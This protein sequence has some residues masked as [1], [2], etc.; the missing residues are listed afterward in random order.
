MYDST[1][2][3]DCPSDGDLYLGYVNGRWATYGRLVTLYGRM[4]VVPCSVNA[5]QAAAVCDTEPGDATPDQAPHF[6]SISRQ[7][8][9][10]KPC[11]YCDRSEE[12]AV[13]QALFAAGIPVDQACLGIATLD[14]SIVSGKTAHGYDIVFCQNRGSAQTGGHYDSS[15]V[16]DN[17]WPWYN[18]V[19]TDPPS[20]PLGANITVKRI[21]ISI[22]TDGNGNGWDNAFEQ[23]GIPWASCVG[24]PFL[25]G[26]DPDI[27]ADKDYPHGTS[28]CAGS[29]RP[30]QRNGLLLVEVM[31]CRPNSTEIVWQDVNES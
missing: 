30:Q 2:A 26:T 14:G 11:I 6:W 17:A 5:F 16:F 7:A 18:V 13:D 8:G 15:V 19:P 21:G 12:A 25:N 24:G 4:K 9:F 10:V 31:G 1:T 22:T 29:A 3:D 28:P 20:L 23:R 27:N